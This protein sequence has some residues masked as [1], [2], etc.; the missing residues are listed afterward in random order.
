[1]RGAA[2]HADLEALAVP[3]ERLAQTPYRLDRAGLAAV[4]SVAWPPR[5]KGTAIATTF[6]PTNSG[7]TRA[8]S[9]WTN[10]VVYKTL[11]LSRGV[12]V[13]TQTD[14]TISAII[15]TS[16]S[17]TSAVGLW[18]AGST[19]FLNPS[20]GVGN[21]PASTLVWI[22]EP[23]NAV[24]ISGSISYNVRALESSAMVNYGACAGLFRVASGNGAAAQS[25]NWSSFNAS[26]ELGVAE[27]AM[28]FAFSPTSTAFSTGDMIA[29]VLGY[30]SVGGNSGGFTA[31]GFYAG[32]AGG[33]SG[34]TFVTFTETITLA[35][36]AAGI[37][38]VGMALT[39]T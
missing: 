2:R 27:A 24:T 3:V 19:L 8:S 20:S 37:P 39:V 7:S 21:L 29:L 14:A 18:G 1:V 30:V 16:W 23:I 6:Y 5:R 33:A 4:A 13:Q 22:S 34:D 38:D 32:T 36:A 25:F 9:T 11:G 31:S 35:T 26:V 15:D 12:G 17:S 10:A 28:T